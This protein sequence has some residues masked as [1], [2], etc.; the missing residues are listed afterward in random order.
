MLIGHNDP[1]QYNEAVRCH[2]GAGSIRY[3]TVL[4]TDAFRTP[5][6]FIHRG[7]LLPGGGIGVHLHEECEEMYSIFDGA[8]LFAHNGHVA[9]LE[10]PVMVPCRKGESHGILN[11]TDQTVQWMNLCVVNPGGQ[12]DATNYGQDLADATPGPSDPIPFGRLDRGLMK[13][14]SDVHQ[15]KGALLFREVWG[16][17]DFRTTWG[18]LHH[19]VLPPD[20]SIGYHRHETMEECYILL[21]GKAR[22][23]VDG[24][25]VEV[26]A[27]DAAPC[28]LGSA[29]GIYN[30]TDEE[31]EILNMAVTM[32]KDR[33]DSAD[34][35]D[36][37]SAR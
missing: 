9:E 16:H 18:F 19:I 15:G 1:G 14:I 17:R 37:L 4:G 5:W 12:Y 22:S 7:V 28:P 6:L 26:V 3:M 36:D 10:G 20:S 35:G 23:T 33:F 34:L 31:L 2:D 30:H 11:H 8:A 29:H 27:G 21:R 32:E 24:E 25:T 13:E